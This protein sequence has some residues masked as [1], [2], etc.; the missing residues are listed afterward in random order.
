[1]WVY[2]VEP[3][4][5]FANEIAFGYDAR[6]WVVAIGE[7][8]D[9]A[10]RYQGEAVITALLGPCNLLTVSVPIGSLVASKHKSAPWLPSAEC[11]AI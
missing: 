8:L 7:C 1:M 11:E 10:K 6:R 5:V 3:P 9:L 4:C 2:L